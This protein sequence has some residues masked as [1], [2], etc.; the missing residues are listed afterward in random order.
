VG[1]VHVVLASQSYGYYWDQGL[2]W[3]LLTCMGREYMLVS[4]SFRAREYLS[5][6]N[7]LVRLF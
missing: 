1:Y 3:P 2:V 6:P 7:V 5:S 4:T